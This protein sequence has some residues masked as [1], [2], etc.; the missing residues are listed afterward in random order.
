MTGEDRLCTPGRRCAERGARRA[1]QVQR[2]AARRHR[3]RIPLGAR[4]PPL[5][6]ATISLDLVRYASPLAPATRCVE[7]VIDSPTETRR[8]GD[9]TAVLSRIGKVIPPRPSAPSRE[10]VSRARRI[11]ATSARLV[12]SSAVRFISAKPNGCARGRRYAD[13][14]T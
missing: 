7:S 14:W 2:L 3:R 1:R 6:A 11:C 8:H 4:P 10:S 9:D 12:V 13:H 5:T